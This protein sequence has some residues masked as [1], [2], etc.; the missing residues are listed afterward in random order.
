MIK[1]S[2]KEFIKLIIST[3]MFPLIIIITLF[4]IFIAAHEAFWSS[5]SKP[6]ETEQ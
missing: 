3:A 2:I 1:Q 5:L 6:T 4:I